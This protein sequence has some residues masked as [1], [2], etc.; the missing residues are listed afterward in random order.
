LGG[1]TTVNNHRLQSRSH[2]RRVHHYLLLGRSTHSR[3]CNCT[4]RSVRN[5]VPDNQ[6][7]QHHPC[8]YGIIQY[9]WRRHSLRFVSNQSGS[10]VCGS[11]CGM[12]SGCV[13]R[14][15]VGKWRHICQ[16]D[17][18]LEPDEL[19]AKLVV[20][21]PWWSFVLLGR[22]HRVSKRIF[23]GYDCHSCGIYAW[24]FFNQ[25]DGGYTDNNWISTNRSDTGDGLLC[26][27]RQ[28]IYVQS[29]CHRRRRCNQHFGV[30]IWD[31]ITF[32]LGVT[33]LPVSA[34]LMATPRCTRTHLLCQ[35]LVDLSWCLAQTITVAPF[36]TPCLSGGQIKN[37]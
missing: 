36:L 9:Y 37:R 6:Y 35:T 22:K 13:G 5:Y 25:R 19:R 14:W 4:C 29:V 16:R 18:A 20:W 1:F 8:R 3:W 33:P 27:Q 34:G 2:K 28:R 21:Y 30:P 12:G 11:P 24:L 15:H 10:R 31:S 32:L 23:H 17:A 7:I 26:S